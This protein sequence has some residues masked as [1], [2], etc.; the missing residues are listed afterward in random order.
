MRSGPD[1]A[2]GTMNRWLLM[3]LLAGAMSARAAG[4]DTNLWTDFRWPRAPAAALTTSLALVASQEWSRA[5]STL[6]EHLA[7]HPKEAGALHLTGLLFWQSGNREEATRRLL[8]AARAP[9]ADRISL[10]ALAALSA[11]ARSHAECVGWLRRATRDLPPADI[12]RWLRKPYFADLCDFPPYRD[13]LL[14]WQLAALCPSSPIVLDRTPRGP[15]DQGAL[16]FL[17]DK[18]GRD[19]LRLPVQEPDPLSLRL[20][21]DVQES[22]P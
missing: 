1:Y 19:L 5:L 22:P 8:R 9:D 6:E 21:V 20:K 4:S 18:G 16:D 10:W 14:D 15:R 13:A 2:A 7:A 11:R 17:E 12:E 3:L